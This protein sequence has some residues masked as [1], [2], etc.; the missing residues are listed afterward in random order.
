MYH[1]IDNER[2]FA[3]QIFGCQMNVYDGDRIT[4]ALISRGFKKTSPEEADVV[5]FVTCSIRDKAE[6]KVSSELGRFSKSWSSAK[7][8]LVAMVGCMAQRTGKIMTE[9]FPW[10]KVVAGPRHLG[11]VPDAIESALADGSRHIILDDDP[12]ALDDL[13]I[14]PM[15]R[16][17][18]YKAYV[19]ITNGCDHFCSY[20]I[21]PYVRG[22]FGSRAP[23]EVIRELELLADSGVREV[24][25]L[26]QN[27]NSYGKDFSNGYRFSSLLAEASA[28]NG[29]K[30]IRFTTSHP[31]DFTDDILD[32]MK[33][34]EK[35]CPGINLPIQS[36]SDRV[37]RDMNRGYTVDQYMDTV[38]RIRQ[39][40]PQAGLTTDIIVGFP[41]ESGDEFADS[42]KL[43]EK[44]RFDIVHSAAYSPRSGTPAA[45][46]TDQ[47]DEEEKSRRLNE[48]NRLQSSIAAEI[49]KELV[50]SVQEIFIDSPAQK[51]DGMMQGRTLTDKVVNVK[52]APDSAGKFFKVKVLNSTA[53]SLEGEIIC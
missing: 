5:V 12:R 32:V 20:C 25:L 39:A 50:G 7:R 14:A 27:V 3:I 43:L 6:Q 33:K 2:T 18:P 10:L 42:L 53:W 15:E 13:N 19:T 36:G 24:T 17:N 28:V 45:E 40:L 26:G 29:L 35:I 11:F 51:G 1:I 48:L 49:N 9:R 16:S 41:G 52:S 31:V 8:P 4:T 37:L 30:R 21:V 34:C 47:I 38:R 22:R 46:R 44:V 23:A